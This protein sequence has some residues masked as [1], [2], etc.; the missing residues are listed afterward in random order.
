MGY[1]TDVSEEHT[2]SVIRAEWE[3]CDET[4]TVQHRHNAVCSSETS[5]KQPIYGASTQ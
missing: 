5:A 4:N 1:V 2:A 3:M